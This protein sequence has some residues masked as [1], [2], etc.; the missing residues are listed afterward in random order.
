VPLP[1]EIT[2][3]SAALLASQGVANPWI[4][5]CVAAAG[6]IVGDSIG[7]YIGHS[8]GRRFLKVL[9]RLFPT[10]VNPRT[11]DLAER[12]FRRHGAKTV[13]FGRFIA[14]LRIFAGPLAGILK[15]P[16]RRFL[17]ANA[18]GGIVWSGIVLW[19]VYFLGVVAE[20]W[21]HRLSWAALIACLVLG[22]IVSIMFRGRLEKYLEKRS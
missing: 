15:M 5:W 16:Y 14:I 4:V 1:G 21:L 19:V 2:L 8:Q 13:F 22:A 12:L 11:I 17:L 3:M 6:A 20:K 7:Y 10:H 18:S 9:G